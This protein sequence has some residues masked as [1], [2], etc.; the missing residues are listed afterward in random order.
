MGL[1]T[2]KFGINFYHGTGC[3]I[4]PRIVLT[5]A[6][7]IY[8]P[9][10]NEPTDLNFYPAVNGKDGKGFPVKKFYY[11]PEYKTKTG[12]E[13]SK[14]DIGVLE[15]EENISEEYGYFGIDASEK[16]A[17]EMM[18]A[19]TCGYPGNKPDRTMWHAV[20]PVEELDEDFLYYSI[21]TV[22]VKGQSGSPIIKREKGTEFV[23][24]VHIGSSGKR[25]NMAV[26]LTPERRRMVNQWVG[27]I[28]RRLNLGRVGFI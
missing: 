23:V 9:K 16:N 13:R 21:P 25:K 15:L 10:F 12:M 3:L 17:E 4:G 22:T 5:C 14:Y 20:G 26:R 1:V 6:H 28:T 2:G 8:D 19:E 18:K 27:E 11:P 24:G 7:N